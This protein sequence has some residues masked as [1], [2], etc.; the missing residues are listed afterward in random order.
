MVHFIVECGFQKIPTNTSQS[1]VKKPCNSGTSYLQ[2]PTVRPEFV[3]ERRENYP[4]HLVYQ[5]YLQFNKS[6]SNRYTRVSDQI[7]LAH[8]LVTN[9]TVVDHKVIPLVHS[10]KTPV[11]R[12]VSRLFSFKIQACPIPKIFGPF[13]AFLYF[14]VP[15]LAPKKVGTFNVH[16]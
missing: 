11:T 7:Q 14:I 8:V 15:A 16:L 6:V 13:F 9:N 3:E 5:G 12:G 1:W 10:G 2:N 4:I